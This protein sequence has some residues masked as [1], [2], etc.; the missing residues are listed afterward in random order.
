M[1][2]APLYRIVRIVGI[3]VLLLMAVAMVYATGISFAYW[4]GIGV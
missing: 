2:S 4:A 3:I 1:Q